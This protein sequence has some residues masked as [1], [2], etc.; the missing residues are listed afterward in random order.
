MILKIAVLGDT[1]AGKSSIVQRVVNDSYD[2]DIHATIGAAFL[3]RV[4]AHPDA[5]GRDVR[6]ELW[7]TAGQE[8]YRS[9][10]P[11]Y[12][13]GANAIWVVAPAGSHPRV[14][15][16]WLRY[17][18]TSK[19]AVVLRVSSKADLAPDHPV[20]AGGVD[21]VTSARS[22]RGIDE[23]LDRT[24]R[25]CELR[26]RAPPCVATVDVAAARRRRCCP[27]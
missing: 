9:L 19:D 26:Y 15:D 23:L 18:H 11:M 17:T 24:I 4:R 10:V 22:G 3:T 21:V 12:T 8:R 1:G 27:Q 6:L 20:S 5:D 16:A 25:E 2:A 13:R 7:D 14:F